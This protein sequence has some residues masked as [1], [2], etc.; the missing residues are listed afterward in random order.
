MNILIV[1]SKAKCKTIERHL[2]RGEWRVMATG[3]HIETLPNDRK[4]HDPKQVKKAAWAARPDALPTPPWVW[5]DRGQAAI[6]AIRAEAAKHEDVQFYLATDPDREGER[7]AWHLERLLSELGP[8]R[9]VTFQEITRPALLQAVGSP[10]SVDQDRVD[11]ALVRVFLDRLVGW[12]ASKQAR[13][14]VGRGGMGRV[15]TP[16]L[17]FLVARELERDAH[18]PIPYFEV[19]VDTELGADTGTWRVRFHEPESADVWRGDD[20]RP[21]PQRTHSRVLAEAALADIEEAAALIL[22]DQKHRDTRQSP[23]QP[24]RTDTLLRAASSRFSWSPKKT[25]KIASAL[26]E[27]GHITYIRTDSTRLS[28]EAVDAA[29]AVVAQA[30]GPEALGPGPSA[31]KDDAAVQD[32]HEAIRPTDLTVQTLPAELEEDA[33]R[34]YALIRAWTLAAF[35]LPAVRRTLT[36]R[37]QTPSGQ[38]DLVTS[39]GWFVDPGW[40][41]AFDAVD[42]PVSVQIVR[43]SVGSSLPTSPAAPDSPNPLL[44]EDAT[45]PP[46]RYSP[47]GVIKIM[48]ESGIGRPS[49]YSST[50]DKL[51]QHGFVEPDEGLAPTTAGRHIWLGVAP[52]YGA[53]VE[54]G[55]FSVETTASLERQLDLI[56]RGEL[57]AGRTWGELSSAFRAAHEQAQAAARSGSLSPRTRQTLTDY[58]EATPALRER[59]GD[60]DALTEEQGRTLK[61]ALL[62]EAFP[63]PPTASQEKRLAGLLGLAGVTLDEVAAAVGLEH[64]APET[65]ADYSK[66]IDHL[67][68]QVDDA[69]PISDRQRKLIL[70]LAEKKGLSEA[71]AC[72]LVDADR[73][74]GLTGGREGTASSLIDKLQSG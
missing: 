42:G 17:G 1:E 18:V 67:S 74:D 54:T 62:S 73:L 66:L 28:S 71:E 16:T 15:Q 13:S 56:E 68:N 9:R 44:K 23:K 27:A 26:Y 39:V 69:R 51:I 55:W 37:G 35:M 40:R 70:R 12:R 22:V 14:S 61:A 30:W 29:R 48:R 43:L 64:S 34:L 10:R 63:L 45:R 60:L 4:K 72:A 46:G 53:E 38:T 24:L 32:A 50:V 58:C 19:R 21:D 59:V 11:A 20:G 2:G 36:L 49:T 52:R 31:G 33:H 65:R 41:R 47:A 7:I 25:A 3:G 6:E 57:S 5:T 8:C